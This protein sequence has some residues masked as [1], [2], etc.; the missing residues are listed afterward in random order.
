MFVSARRDVGASESAVAVYRN[1]IGIDA[2]LRL[3]IGIDLADKTAVAHIC[4]YAA[5]GNN[6][7]G[8]HN[9]ASGG[10]AQSDITGAGIVVTQ[11]LSLIHISE[12]TRLLSISYAVF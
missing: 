10:N 4:A 1:Q 9:V 12:P 8:V 6:V 7:V 11:C 2:Y 3:N 5:N